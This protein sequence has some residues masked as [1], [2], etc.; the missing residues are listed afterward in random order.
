MEKKENVNYPKIF[1]VDERVVGD[2]VMS[3]DLR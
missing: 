1:I 2:I 3:R